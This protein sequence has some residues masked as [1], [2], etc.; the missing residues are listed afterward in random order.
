MHEYKINLDIDLISIF[1]NV[2]ITVSVHFLNYCPAMWRGHL[3]NY[4]QL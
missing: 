4:T 2:L 3:K 1:V